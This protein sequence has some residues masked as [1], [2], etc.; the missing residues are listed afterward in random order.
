MI[1]EEL[2][3]LQDDLAKVLHRVKKPKK[4][5]VTAGMPYA[6]GPLHIGHLA[7]AHVPAD[8]YSRWLKM[9]IGPENV[10]FVC[11]T[12][13]HGSNSEVAAKTKNISTK[14]FI[15]EIHSKQQKTLKDY[16]IEL[17]VYTGTSREETFE[18]H[19]NYCQD[20]LRK[21]HDNKFLTKKTS[22]QWYDPK[23]EM[24]LPDRFVYGECPKCD[25]KKAYSEEC[26]SCG[27]NYKASE[28]KNPKSTV[29]DGKPVLKDTDHW[30]LDMWQV[31]DELKEWIEGK[32]KTW[33]KSVYLETINTVYPS[34]VFSN[35]DEETFK[36]LKVELPKHK[37]RY[38]PG[39][40]IVVQFDNLV[41][42][43]KGKQTLTN[44]DIE[45]ELMDG[46]AHRS[47]TRDV[48][49]GIPVPKDRDEGMENKSLYVWP[50]SL[51]A[52]ISFT[53]TAL[54]KKGLDPEL[55]K[56][57][58]TDPES[59]VYQFLGQD[60]VYF[61]VLMQGA[62]WL[63][64]QE[65]KNR[66]PKKGELQLTDIFS[67]YHLHMDGQKMS[68]STG[69]F[70]TGDQFLEE[71]GYDSDQVRYFLSLL[72]LPE[73]NSNFD[74]ETFQKRNEFLAGPLNA[75]FE[76]P[77]SA[78]H[79]KFDGKVPTGKL[80]GKTKKETYKIVQNYIRMMEKA[81]YPK[82][83][84]MIENYARIINSLFTQF[85]P[86]DDRFDMEQRKDALFSSFFILKNIMIMLSPF[87]PKTMDKLRK[88]LNLG[89]SVISIEELGK[90][91]P[92]GHL[93]GEK[94]D[95]FPA[96]KEEKET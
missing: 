61:Y 58:W 10:L 23:I 80:I 65:A 68:K 31:T 21:L 66:M 85:K 87:A 55:Y 13:D 91:M 20:F 26:D 38:A 86:H 52:P 15:D 95:Y 83:L 7:G 84:F 62:M 71:M 53:Q 64:T 43:E 70:Y 59:N 54:K 44:N 42:L 78:V 25:H 39:K 5:V 33:R 47:I 12:D 60:N 22:E 89:A 1:D 32:K 57:F 4:A 79:S 14:E 36:G 17:D 45:T 74:F 88:S 34:L 3:G 48:S 28:L 27:A 6:N 9:L 73:K 46:W 11:G 56:E 35:K 50:E 96:P 69:N 92:K 29:S 75:A 16:S 19:K 41:D 37:S 82:I 94:A 24:F 72:S 18:H 40:K 2:K 76:K 77:I 90:P 8:I 49:W 51:I 30:W 63:G 93:I 81:D 67:N